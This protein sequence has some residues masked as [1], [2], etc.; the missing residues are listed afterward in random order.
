MKSF[1]SAV[2]FEINKMI[3]ICNIYITYMQKVNC[4]YI[5]DENFELSVI[6]L[7]KI[8]SKIIHKSSRI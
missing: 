7:L 6:D 4:N 8:N 2:E 1:L 3:T 5:I